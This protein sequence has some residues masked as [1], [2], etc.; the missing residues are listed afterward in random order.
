M[1]GQISLNLSLKVRIQTIL[2]FLSDVLVD[3]WSPN[4]KR[5]SDT[6]V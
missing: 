5:E 2:P 4:T 6:Q 1:I 3:E